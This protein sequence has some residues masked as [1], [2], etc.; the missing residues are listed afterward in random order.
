MAIEIIEKPFPVA[1][2]VFA[3]A[4]PISGD[5]YEIPLFEIADA[6]ENPDISVWLHLNL[7]NSQIQRWLENTPLIPERVVEMIQEGVN[8]SRLERIE[9]LNDCLLMVM[10]DF[11][12]EFGEESGDSS[13]G[14]LWAIVTP[15]LMISLRN[16]PLR[17]TDKLR[18][19]LRGG[20]L[21]PASAIE[22]FH[23]LLDLRAEHLR[24]LLA[25]LSEDMDDLEEK[26]LKGREF[27]EHENLGRIRIQCS[28]LRRHF[29]PELIALHRL[30]K[31]LPYWFSDE[32]KNRLNDD[33]DLLSY[34]V[35]EISSLYDRAKVLQDEQAAHVA[36]F[37]A[38]NLQVL[39]VM[40]VIFLPMTLIT[41]VMGMNMED[42]P[43]LKGSF[44]EV[45]VIMSITGAA[46]Y[47]A[48]K[49]KRI[50]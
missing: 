12:Q 14:T 24:T 49:L 20:Q 48:L 42:L 1:G 32:D 4:M 10:N 46:V 41:G 36:E 50:I 34:L 5:G 43:G 13:L 38:K 26:L 17:T 39:S 47:A 16:N 25:H 33:L 30:L 23:E 22:L 27:P 40:T 44:Y 15:R 37:N 18:Y 28:R 2:V 11:Q 21:N 8:L 19:D 7:S 45:M 35:Q 29:S 31:R 6:L 3:W 9:K